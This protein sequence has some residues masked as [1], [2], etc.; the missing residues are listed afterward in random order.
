MSIMAI[1]R[2]SGIGAEIFDRFRLE[3]PIEPIPEGAISHHIAFDGH[4]M[5]CV[6][7]WESEAQL[8]AFA[9]DRLNPGLVRAGL[10]VVAPQV[11]ELHA[12]WTAADAERHNLAAPAPAVETA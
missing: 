8:N 1:Y 9:R 7:I 10:P 12:L 3:V 6:D 11:L 5:V 2:S 4:D